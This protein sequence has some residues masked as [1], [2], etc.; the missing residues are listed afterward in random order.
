MS[1]FEFKLLP[2]AMSFGLLAGCS[3]MPEWTK[4]GTW[5][6]GVSGTEKPAEKADQKAAPAAETTQVAKPATATTA[7][8]DPVIDPLAPATQEARIKPADAPTQFPNINTA[9]DARQ[10]T[11]TE[12]QRRDIRDSLVADRDNAQH[13]AEEL[14]GGQAPAAPPPP[15]AKPAATTTGTADPADP[16]KKTDGTP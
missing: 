1:R 13:S 5:V 14:R 3:T 11:T 7:E 15:A 12:S 4:P 8:T 16:A 10:L 2:V 6:D 9:P